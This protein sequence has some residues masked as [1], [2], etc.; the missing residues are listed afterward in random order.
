VR[1][2]AFLTQDRGS[3]AHSCELRRDVFADLERGHTNVRPNRN[4]QLGARM[5]QRAKRVRYDASNGAPPPGMHRRNVAAPRMRNQHRHAVSGAGRH[6]NAVVAGNEC[7]AFLVGNDSGIARTGDRVHPDP[8]NLALF[9]Q[10]PRR[11]AERVGE[12]CAVLS[13]RLVAIAEMKPEVQRV[14]GD[15]AHS[16]LPGPEHM[17]ELVLV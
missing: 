2:L 5:T 12:T 16:T 6:C 10:S 8:V 11:D 1:L 3:A 7:I 14:E 9:E 4:E 17:A 13:H 15:V